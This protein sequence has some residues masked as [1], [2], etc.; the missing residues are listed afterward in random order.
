MVKITMI[1]PEAY[2]AQSKSAAA[3]IVGEYAEYIPNS[4]HIIHTMAK[5]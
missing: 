4:L 3:W 1:I 5:K 2:D